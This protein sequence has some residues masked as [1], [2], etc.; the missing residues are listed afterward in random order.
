MEEN[1]PQLEDTFYI[2]ATDATADYVTRVLKDGD[3]FAVFD[4]HGDIQSAGLGQEG[5]YREGTRFLSR[6]ELML[7]NG[8]PFLLDSTVQEDN[9]LFVV[10]LTNPDVYRSGQL[11]L[12]RGTLHITR[13]KLLRASMCFETLKFI[14]YGL[15]PV[16]VRFSLEFDADFADVF[17][18][19]GIARERR[20]TRSETTSTVDQLWFAYRGLD[21]VTRR[22]RIRCNP[23]PNHWTASKAMFVVLL[24]SKEEKEFNLDYGCEIGGASLA[25]VNH[26]HAYSEAKA[27]VEMLQR[28]ACLVRSSN[29]EFN[30]WLARSASD[31]NMMITSTPSGF[32]P[33]AGVPWYSTPFGRD[34]IITAFEYLWVN[35][36]IARGVLAFLATLQ[37]Q[38]WDLDRDAEPGKI[39]HET[40]KGEMA[41]L[42]EIPFDCYY[43]S[44]DATPL[45]VLLAGTYFAWT[46]DLEFVKSIWP[47]VEFA[48]RWMDNYADR[49]RDG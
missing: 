46:G 43:G 8:R 18:V 14:N 39:L 13:T 1:S 11:L 3:S 36:E 7:G 48:L 47:Q 25:I 4:P 27:S 49:D 38:K 42:R 32:Y 37:A 24:G 10:H 41:A 21:G 17:E 44:I 22:T 16:E 45:F 30:R 26:G 33:Y 40:R 35:P 31:L 28:R 2:L 34:G 5:I 9:L 29:D 19:R 23:A 6:L 12:P 15:A 20:G